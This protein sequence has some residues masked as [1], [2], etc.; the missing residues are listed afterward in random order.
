M[1]KNKIVKAAIAA[2][3]ALGLGSVATEA[4]AAKKKPELKKCFGVVKK[5]MN[6]CGAKGHGCAGQSK[7]DG[8]PQEW[9]FLPKGTCEKLV[10]GNLTPPKDKNKK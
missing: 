2:V 10:N 6:D 3:V 5:G 8:A 4:S 1:D 9:I 7:V